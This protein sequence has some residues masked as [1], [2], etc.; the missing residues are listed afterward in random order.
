MGINESELDKMLGT[1]LNE[2]DEDHSGTISVDEFVKLLTSS[3]LHGNLAKV[4]HA[5]NDITT[6]LIKEHNRRNLVCVFV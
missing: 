2:M 5:F 6:D 1:I 4:Q 3:D